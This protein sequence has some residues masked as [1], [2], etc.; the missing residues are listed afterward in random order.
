MT[1][2]PKQDKKNPQDK[3]AGLSN[4]QKPFKVKL[5]IVP[6]IQEEEGKKERTRYKIGESVK[7]QFDTDQDCYLTLIDI[8]TSGRI[9]IIMPNSLNVDNFVKGGRTLYY[10]EGNWDVACIIQGPTGTERIKAFATLDPVNLFDIDLRDPSALFYTISES[11]L[12][13]RIMR[14]KQKLD[15]L[16]PERWAEALVEFKIQ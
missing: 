6:K 10:P 15:K 12:E 1:S 8:G 13:D 14:M 9:H 2:G 4:T 3:L 5:G 7:I 11:A 16:D